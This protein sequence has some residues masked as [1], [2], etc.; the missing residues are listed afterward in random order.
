MKDVS[1][2]NSNPQSPVDKFVQEFRAAQEKRNVTLLEDLAA[3]EHR[4]WQ[5]WALNILDSEEDISEARKERWRR[6]AFTPYS[7]LTEKEKDQ[8]R[9]YAKKVLLIVNKYF[10]IY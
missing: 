10:D 8:D 7:E 2:P 6:L 3:L 4:Q 1:K 9:V 5:D